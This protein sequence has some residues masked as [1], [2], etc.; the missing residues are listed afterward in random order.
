MNKLLSTREVAK[1]L[2]I[3]ITTVYREIYSRHINFHKIGNWVR[4][5][6][7]DLEKYLIINKIKRIV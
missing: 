7:E 1:I 3:S 5:K 6:E 4:I 2:N